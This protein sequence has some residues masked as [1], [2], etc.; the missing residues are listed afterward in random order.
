[1]FSVMNL[2]QVPPRSLLTRR[3]FSV[4]A[5]TTAVRSGAPFTLLNVTPSPKGINWQSVA[6]AAGRSGKNMLLPCGV[7][8]P[9]A[10]NIVRF[11]P[12]VFPL[13]LM[14]NT[15]AAQLGAE[16]ALTRSL[17][18]SDS[19][20]VLAPFID[21]V[22]PL[23][24]KIKIITDNPS[25]YFVAAQR[26]MERFG[27]SLTIS[28]SIGSTE[29]FD[30]AI[31]SEATELARVNYAVADIGSSGRRLIIPDEYIRLCPSGIDVFDFAAALY[32]CSGVRAIGEL[33]LE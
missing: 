10:V 13:R 12:S 22:V 17:L 18:V 4:E 23:A 8:P 28:D 5:V 6:A 20:A 26:V 30:A 2:G 19:R 7:T 21:I 16:G 15:A 25:L 9:A 32:E 1:M 27:A 24:A 31:V 11:K 33:K 29:K 3:R 14:L